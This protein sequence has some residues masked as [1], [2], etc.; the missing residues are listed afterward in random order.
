M[1]RNSQSRSETKSAVYEAEVTPG[2]EFVTEQE[3]RE[4]GA[5][6]L[7]QNPGEVGFSYAG[8]P[9]NLLGLSTVQSIYSRQHFAIP[10][11]K[12]L[13]GNTNFPRLLTQIEHARQL[14]PAA[15]YRSFYVAAAG[16]ESSV[17]QRIKAEVAQA[18]GLT[19]AGEKGDLWLRIRP[20]RGGWETLVRLSPRPL[21][22]RAWRICNFEG[23]LNAATANAMIRL[24]QPQP[25]D[26]FVNLGCGSGTLL[27]ERLNYGPAA[28]VVGIDHDATA[29]NC[30]QTNVAASVAHHQINLQLADLTRL[31][32]ASSSASVLC[33]DLPF[34]QL[35]GS[36]QANLR[37]YP[38][39]LREAARVA[40]HEARFVLITHEVKLTDALLAQDRDWQT[41]R[42]IRVNLRGLHPRIYCLRRNQRLR[43]QPHELVGFK[44]DAVSRR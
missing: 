41:E 15:D 5:Q 44:L 18:T 24:T 12:A 21:V 29:L 33:A 23:A 17:M 35:S 42:V 16:S 8:D 2:L 28:N 32:F 25:D 22:T 38:L 43:R 10:R 27:I 31:P 20:A 19:A 26:T 13:L 40:D 9:L 6:I 4:L 1:K 7:D 39:M 30:A 11:P 3:L 37:L 14:L 36:H 34:G